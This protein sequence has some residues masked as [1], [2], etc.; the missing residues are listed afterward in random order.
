[1]LLGWGIEDLRESIIQQE[2]TTSHLVTSATNIIKKNKM[3]LR[4][5]LF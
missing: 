5:K 3:Q 2:K 1:V 4:T